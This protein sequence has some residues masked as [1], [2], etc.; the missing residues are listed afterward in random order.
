MD[1]GHP[2][3]INGSGIL[4]QQRRKKQLAGP[5]YRLV[6]RPVHHGVAISVNADYCR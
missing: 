6:F 2:A 4:K 5:G 1:S 3:R